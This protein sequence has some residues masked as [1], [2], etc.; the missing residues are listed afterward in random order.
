MFPAFGNFISSCSHPGFRRI[1]FPTYLAE[2]DVD[3]LVEPAIGAQVS[4]TAA[5]ENMMQDI[6]VI[7]IVDPSILLADGIVEGSR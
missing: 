5:M 4:R 2:D 1:E 7:P 3:S 6:R